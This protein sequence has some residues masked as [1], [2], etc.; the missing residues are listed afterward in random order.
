MYRT[1]SIFWERL[2]YEVGQKLRDNDVTHAFNKYYSVTFGEFVLYRKRRSRAY[3]FLRTLVYLGD[4][5]RSLSLAVKIGM[6]SFL[7]GLRRELLLMHR[8][9]KGSRE[10]TAVFQLDVGFGLG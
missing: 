10:S 6:N 7:R 4:T 5:T 3:F 9:Q 8:E 2:N 1:F